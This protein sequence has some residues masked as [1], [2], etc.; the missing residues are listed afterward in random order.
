VLSQL[1]HRFEGSLIA[2]D[3]AGVVTVRNQHRNGS[4]HAVAARMQWLC[5]DPRQLERWGPELLDT[6]TFATRNQISPPPGPRY[7]YGMPLLA[8]LLP[9][10][11][12]SYKLNLFRL[13][14]QPRR[15][16]PEGQHIRRSCMAYVLKKAARRSM[17]AEDSG[18][19]AEMNTGQT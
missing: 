10:I 16:H 9:F 12:N 11:V 14:T 2:F 18:S 8:R 1:A 3:T 17:A 15:S 4:M 19:P 13:A 7:R 5:D 6:R